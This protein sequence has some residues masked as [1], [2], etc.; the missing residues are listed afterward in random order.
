[1]S[2][3]FILTKTWQPIRNRYSIFCGLG[4]SLKGK[5][6]VLIHREC[7]T[8]SRLQLTHPRFVEADR[9]TGMK[10]KRTYCCRQGQKQQQHTLFSPPKMSVACKY[11]LSDGKLNQLYHSL[12]S[13]FA[14]VPLLTLTLV[15]IQKN[16]CENTKVTK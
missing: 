9:R 6:R 4:I 10:A 12:Q 5:Q 15:W 3:Y 11:Y 1:M 8:Y 2:C 13:G 14:G 7:I 16:P